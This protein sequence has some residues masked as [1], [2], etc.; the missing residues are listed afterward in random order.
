MA[1]GGLGGLGTQP[2]A[3]QAIR[4]AAIV[5]SVLAS[6]A[7][8]RRCAGS[9][10]IAPVVPWDSTD[11]FAPADSTEP[12][13]PAEPTEKAEPAEPIEPIDSAEPTEPIDRNEPVEA[14]DR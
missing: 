12:S 3:R 1:M 4:P 9:P 2:Q 8:A 14:I 10:R 5:S 11:A 13:E 6:T 7:A